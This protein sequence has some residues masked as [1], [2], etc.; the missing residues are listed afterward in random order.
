MNPAPAS[1]FAEKYRDLRGNSGDAAIVEY[2]DDAFGL[3]FLSGSFVAR[4]VVFSAIFLLLSALAAI[5][6]RQKKISFSN[7]I[8][9]LVAGTS[10]GL[11]TLFTI[12]LSSSSSDG[13]VSTGGILS[14]W[15]GAKSLTAIQVELAVCS[16]SILY[17]FVVSPLLQKE[18]RS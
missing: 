11:A 15:M 4:D 9:P 3:V 5:A 7:R 13:L 2:N 1:L 16:I 18:D 8:P 10:L 6:V 17:G 12:L 14:D